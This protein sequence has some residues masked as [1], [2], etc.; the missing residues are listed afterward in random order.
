MLPSTGTIQGL[1]ALP[2]ELG[3]WYRPWPDEVA[4]GSLRDI[5]MSVKKGDIGGIQCLQPLLAMAATPG[6]D[7]PP[8]PGSRRCRRQPRVCTIRPV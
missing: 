3:V 4:S 5:Y 2:G 1:R 6:S 8:L 7:Q